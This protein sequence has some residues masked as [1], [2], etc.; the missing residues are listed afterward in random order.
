[1]D[2]TVVVDVVVV[3]VGRVGRRP[4][5]VVVVGATVVIVEAVV[6]AGTVGVV[7]P[8]PVV[9]VEGLVVVVPLAVVAVVPCFA[10]EAATA[11][12]TDV[13]V[14]AEGAVVDVDVGA[15]GWLDEVTPV[16]P[17][18]EPLSWGTVVLWAAAATGG[19][20]GAGPFVATP[21]ISAT[22]TVSPRTT[23][24]TRTQR[25]LVQSPLRLSTGR[26][27]SQS[28]RDRRPTAERRRSTGCR[29]TRGLARRGCPTGANAPSM[30]TVSL[31]MSWVG[32]MIRTGQPLTITSRAVAGRPSGVWPAPRTTVSPPMTDHGHARSA[33]GSSA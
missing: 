9:A 15:G 17:G 32:T 25:S 13:D 8:G 26:P 20:F 30:A 16:G 14:A 5:V 18:V 6:G 3:V 23:T 4:L 28:G 11:G 2:G 22:A 10:L 24:P 33:M 7:A 29:V 1:M 12:L 21:A 31:G 19:C 27:P